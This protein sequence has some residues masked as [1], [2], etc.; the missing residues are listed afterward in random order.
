MVKSHMEAVEALSPVRRCRRVLIAHQ[1]P[2]NQSSNSSRDRLILRIA[3]DVLAVQERYPILRY[4]LTRS[5]TSPLAPSSRSSTNV[6]YV[7]EGD[8]TTSSSEDISEPEWVARAKDT[9]SDRRP[10][11]SKELRCRR[12][13][14]R[15]LEQVLVK[16]E[17]GDEEGVNLEGSSS[18]TAEK[19]IPNPETILSPTITLSVHEHTPSMP[20]SSSSPRLHTPSLSL[21]TNVDSFNDVPAAASPVTLLSAR[22]MPKPK[23]SNASRSIPRPDSHAEA[24]IRLLYIFVL[25]NSQWTYQQ[26]FAGLAAQLYTIYLQTSWTTRVRSGKRYRFPIARNKSAEEQTYWGFCALVREFESVIIGT[27]PT[28]P[29]EVS[30]DSAIACLD[31]RVR[32]A[33]E[34]LW[35]ILQANNLEPSQPVYSA[36]WLTNLLVTAVPPSVIPFL[37]DFLLASRASPA[38]YTDASDALVDISAAVMVSSRGAILGPVAQNMSQVGGSAVP[39]MWHGIYREE[40]MSILYDPSRQLEIL[41]A[42]PIE[43]ES[44]KHVLHIANQLRDERIAG[45][46]ASLN[47]IDQPFLTAPSG[48]SLMT[49]ATLSLKPYLNAETAQSVVR[50]SADWTIGTWKTASSLPAS[51]AVSSNGYRG[52]GILT[53]LRSWSSVKNDGSDAPSMAPDAQPNTQSTHGEIL[54]TGRRSLLSMPS[55]EAASKP[56]YDR[57]PETPPSRLST[58]QGPRPLL[59]SSSARRVSDRRDSNGSTP[60]IASPSLSSIGSPP[61]TH[62]M[63]AT[64]GLYMLGSR[65]GG[66]QRLR[67]S[68]DDSQL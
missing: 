43:W 52:S 62:D 31:R 66:I 33:D 47:L 19:K 10:R 57:C 50:T 15:R 37:W 29:P 16:D 68:E 60:S 40:A 11:Q 20:G 38:T 13:L 61:S 65:Q 67:Q 26:N 42:L 41:R 1:Q 59:L 17:N 12:A 56:E 44:C 21:S 36:G 49:K 30:L 58:L 27:T 46:H 45:G 7:D 5:K 23:S 2:S 35:S 53:K 63:H 9:M 54:G 32:W 55:Q 8:S 48:W 22:P 28:T 6:H 24:V 39:G 3:R 64:S 25:S 4:P 34:P 51:L 18:G 14:F